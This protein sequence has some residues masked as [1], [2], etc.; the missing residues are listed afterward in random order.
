MG[1]GLVKGHRGAGG[2]VSFSR[3][4]SI[5]ASTWRVVGEENMSRL[6]G[7]CIRSG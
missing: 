1:R 5:V 6:L 4:G 2:F 3:A 7:I